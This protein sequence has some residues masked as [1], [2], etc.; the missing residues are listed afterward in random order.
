MDPLDALLD[1]DHPRKLEAAAWAR[2]ELEPDAPA[3]AATDRTRS[4]D[5][6]RW[7]RSA[8]YGILGLT[9]DPAFGGQG[10][11]MVETLLTFEGIGLGCEDTGFAFAL[12]SQVFA[13]QRALEA[14][15]TD[16]HKATWL[17]KL[18]AGEALG[19]FAM[20][21]PDAGSDTAAIA[22]TADPD[23]TGGY[24]L[25]GTKAWVTMGPMCDVV[26]VFATVDP[27]LGRWGSTAFVMEADRPGITRGPV[28]P[29]LGL[30][31]SP[32]GSITFDDVA[33][34]ESDRMGAEGAGGGIFTSAVQAERA[35]LYAV[36][37]GATERVMHQS[38]ERASRRQQFNQ[39][40]GAFQ[41]VSNRIA[42]MKLHHEAARLLVY[43]AA[44]LHDLGRPVTMAAALAKLETS[45]KAI[46]T[47]L[48]AIRIHGAEGYTIEG[49][50]EAS[51][52]HAVGGLAYSG[53]SDIQR[54]IIARLLGADRAPRRRTTPNESPASNT[55]DS[56]E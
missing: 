49:G 56:N 20:T 17:P 13:M 6:A 12:A 52:R 29:K 51:L 19:S 24:R 8:D 34:T 16:E 32:F 2:A 45:E 10:R 38:I 40:I 1:L 11:S 47:A 3:G 22:T 21:E 28:I 26:I 35:F 9:V 15:G 4:F 54:N 5:V 36:Q 18:I 53:T 31:S 43:K 55:T 44:I 25:N 14:A 41:S 46:A 48:D 42:D 27:T 7:K 33:L 50:V 39:P 30:E 23:G 37:L